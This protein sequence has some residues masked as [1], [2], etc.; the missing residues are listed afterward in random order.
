[1]GDEP[2]Q[3]VRAGSIQVDG[4]AARH[5]AVHHQPVAE[6][7]VA[8]L[9]DFLAQDAAM[10]VDQRVG[11]VVADEAEVVDVVGDPL[12][13]GQER[14]QPVR[15]WRRL[16]AGGSLGGTGE[17]QGVGHGAVARDAAGEPSA[18]GEIGTLEQPLDA[19]VDVAQP[20][21]EAGDGLAIGGEAEMAGLDDAGMDRADRD[22]V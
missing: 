2:A 9:Q 7:G 16:G 10:G 5:D 6:A 21:L 8:G 4:R 20:L 19:L 12:E 17:G 15:P 3:T 14:T 1:M 18:L 13:L 22:L 11:G